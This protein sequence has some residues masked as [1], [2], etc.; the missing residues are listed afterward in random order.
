[1]TKKDAGA[2][3]RPEKPISEAAIRRAAKALMPI[4]QTIV[5]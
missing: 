1:M 2:M 3:I 4:L 5:E